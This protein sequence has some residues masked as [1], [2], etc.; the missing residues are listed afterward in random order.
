MIGLRHQSVERIV[1]NGRGDKA[2]EY[3]PPSISSPLRYLVPA[4]SRSEWVLDGSARDASLVDDVVTTAA[5]FGMQY[6]VNFLDNDR[7]LQA[8]GE[9]HSRDQQSAYRWPAFLAWLGRRQ[10]AV[11]ACSQVVS[12]IEARE[13]QAARELRLFLAWLVANL[14][15]DD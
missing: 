7:L 13:D 10:E 3:V 5:G 15:G 4:A 1:S 8:L 2:H 12:E 14:P 9:A 11:A 6:V